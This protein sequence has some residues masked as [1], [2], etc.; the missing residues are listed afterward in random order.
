MLQQQTGDATFLGPTNLPHSLIAIYANQE[1]L[2]YYI[3]AKN[4]EQKL[5]NLMDKHAYVEMQQLVADMIPIFTKE[6]LSG[7][8]P[9]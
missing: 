4:L 1:E 3:E 8:N 6:Y 9:K 2:M 5:R 7:E